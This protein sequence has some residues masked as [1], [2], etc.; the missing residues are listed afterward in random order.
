MK[1]LRRFQVNWIFKV[2]FVARAI[3]DAR[4]NHGQFVQMPGPRHRPSRELI[5]AFPIKCYHHYKSHYHYKIFVCSC[6]HR[7]SM[8]HMWRQ[9]SV[10]TGE[11]RQRTLLPCQL[12]PRVVHPV[13]RM[14]WMFRDAVCR[15][16][17]VGSEHPHVCART[18]STHTSWQHEALCVIFVNVVL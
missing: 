11:H 18:I 3:V 16:N 6:H 10:H 14:G 5:I 1:S 15:G 12:W 8:L 2:Q 17:G 7:Y 9:Q 4:I 13:W